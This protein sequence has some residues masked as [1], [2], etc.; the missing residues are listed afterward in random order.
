M[1]GELLSNL[2]FSNPGGS[3]PIQSLLLAQKQTCS[4]E[5]A[6]IDEKVPSLSE[7]PCTSETMSAPSTTL[8]PNGKKTKGRV[9]IKMEYISNK[10]RR[11]TTFSKRK[12]GIMKKAYELATLTGTQVMLAVVSETNHIYTF[13]TH[14]LQPMVASDEGRAFIQNCLNAP[15]DETAAN[16]IC[17]S[18]FT[19]EQIG[20][21]GSGVTNSRKRKS[22]FMDSICPMPTMVQIKEMKEELDSDDDSASDKTPDD[23]N[24]SENEDSDKQQETALLLQKRLK[25]AL[26][27]AAK[28]RQNQ[29]RSKENGQ[30][31]PA[32]PPSS[33]KANNGSSAL[34][35]SNSSGISAL[36]PFMLQGIV[37]NSSESSS[38]PTSSSAILQ[39]PQGT[40]YPNVEGLSGNGSFTNEESTTQ[41]L[42]NSLSF[43]PVALQQFLAAATLNAHL[44][45]SNSNQTDLS[46]L[47][48]LT[49]SFAEHK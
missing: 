5:M 39:L 3:G 19:F 37:S 44:G 29:K 45:D 6:E 15:H 10:L 36:L 47:A 2:N 49:E 31:S 41:N 30:N 11:Y 21:S 18:E 48:A 1:N 20:T 26:R 27:V 7:S 13:A 25:E 8:L 40:V 22:D 46:T 16:N 4:S 42:L 43:N 23:G 34:L 33:K 28:E 9:K 24:D 35:D 32:G 14:K 17:R 38:P 12:S